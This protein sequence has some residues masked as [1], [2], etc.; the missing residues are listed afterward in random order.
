[1]NI[2]EAADLAY[3][4]NIKLLI[5]MHFDLYDINGADPSLFTNYIDSK[6][7]SLRYM[8][9]KPKDSLII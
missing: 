5:P 6:Y 9:M 4:S 7:P 8:V 3:A 1:M 2:Y